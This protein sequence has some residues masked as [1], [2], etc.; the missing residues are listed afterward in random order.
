MEIESRR[1]TAMSRLEAEDG[2]LV[3]EFP[4]VDAV[5]PLR[6]DTTLLVEA[7]LSL[8]DGAFY[9]ARADRL[10]PIV[11]IVLGRFGGEGL[12]VSPLSALVASVLVAESGGGFLPGIRRE[13]LAAR[14]DAGTELHD[15]VAAHLQSLPLC[16]GRRGIIEAL[17]GCLGVESAEAIGPAAAAFLAAS[18]AF[19]LDLSEDVDLLEARAAAVLDR[20]ILQRRLDAD[21]ALGR[22]D[23]MT[24]RVRARAG[25]LPAGDPLA[26]SLM[27]GLRT[28]WGMR[29]EPHA[30]TIRTSVS[31][32]LQEAIA[33]LSAL[34]GGA[35]LVLQPG[36]G[37]PLAVGG[38]LEA[39]L[40]LSVD[41]SLGCLVPEDRAPTVLSLT[42]GLLG[43]AEALT[44]LAP[45]ES[46]KGPRHLGAVDSM[47]SGGRTEDMSGVGPVLPAGTLSPEDAWLALQ[48]FD[49]V[50]GLRVRREGR[51][52]AFVAP[53]AVGVMLARTTV[54]SSEPRLPPSI[55][56]DA[57]EAVGFAVP[58]GLWVAMD[59]KVLRRGASAVADD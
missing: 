54:E 39:G 27:E 59:G 7:Y 9:E 21:E 5:E 14:L 43:A 3:V 23:S 8:R 57:A 58:D 16:R 6:G 36:T 46:A 40:G 52:I 25:G 44:G 33:G 28:R 18:A 47:H 20:L 53:T 50:D 55:L 29:L 30:V 10:L 34:R 26:A 48:S 17:R 49:L 19:E 22:L 11:P 15:R 45:R 56:S 32:D 2:R 41:S 24:A 13:V 4:F 12:D 42:G 38:D 31:A 1:S 37:R 35:W 51:V